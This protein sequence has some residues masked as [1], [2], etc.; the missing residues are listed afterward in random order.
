MSTTAAKKEAYQEVIS[1]RVRKLH[2]GDVKVCSAGADVGQAK[3]TQRRKCGARSV[4]DS[5]GDRSG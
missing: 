5:R 2:G 1:I 3:R 4:E